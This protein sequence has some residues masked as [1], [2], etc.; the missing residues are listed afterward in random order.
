MPDET[1]ARTDSDAGAGGEPLSRWQRIAACALG[2]SSAGAG[3]VSVFLTT[4]QA[5]SVA[6]LGVGAGFLIMGVN[7]TPIIKAKLKDYELTMAP[8]RHRVVEQALSEPPEEASKTLDVL[9]QIDPGARTDP[10]VRRAIG[11]VYQAEVH[12][13]LTRALVG[14]D[15]RVTD[16]R[17]RG[18]DQG[19]DI[20]IRSPSIAI[21]VEVKHTSNSDIPLSANHVRQA[22]AYASRSVV[23]FLVVTNH[24]LSNNI[25]E[26]AKPVD[27]EGRRVQ[28]VRWSDRQDDS[29]LQLALNRLLKGHPSDTY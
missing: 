5:G 8:R 26:E 24:R 10:A 21:N 28:F 6:L 14:T 15:L 1:E 4:N 25:F 18:K 20:A 29:A 23:P 13:A 9:Q 16:Q 2:L 3:G 12:A 17:L 22:Y 7:G 27:P 19:F 11:E